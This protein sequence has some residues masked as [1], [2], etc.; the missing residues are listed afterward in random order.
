MVRNSGTGLA[1]LSSNTGREMSVVVVVSRI[2]CIYSV[3]ALGW[4]SARVA[5]QPYSPLSFS[6]SVFF[7]LHK[8]PVTPICNTEL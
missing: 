4:G 3:S 1:R 7:L 6:S 8:G 2:C 5:C